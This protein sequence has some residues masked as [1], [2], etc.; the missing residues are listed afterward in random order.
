MADDATTKPTIETVLDRINALGEN[1]GG[2]LERVE[3]QVTALRSDM[4]AGLRQIGRKIQV[5]N[6]NILTVQADHRDLIR[7]VEDLES[8]AS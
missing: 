2:R 5:L 4:E 3:Q 1:L 8:K 6:D 7:R